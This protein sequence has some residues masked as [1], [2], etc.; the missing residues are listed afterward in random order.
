MYI[1]GS[2]D[3]S[4]GGIYGE[5][6]LTSSSSDQELIPLLKQLIAMLESGSQFVLSSDLLSG[7]GGQHLH[8][9]AGGQQPVQQVAG[10]S[11]SNIVVQKG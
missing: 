2:Y 9:H 4:I 6:N 7:M 11:T 8:L 5:L 10:T 1:V 3:C